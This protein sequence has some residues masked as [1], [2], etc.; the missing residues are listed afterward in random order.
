MTPPNA[1]L[2]FHLHSAIVVT[3]A[4]IPGK[5]APVLLTAAMVE[6]MGRGSVIVDLAAE[7]GGNCEL[8]RAGEDV[9]AH[10]VL[11]RGPVN[12][13]ATVPRHAS[14]M[15]SHNVTAFLLNMI[16]EGEMAVD[17]DDEIA[18]ES[19]LTHGGEIVHAGVLEKLR[20]D[21]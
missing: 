8:T 17:S 13:P 12:L 10:G 7:S 18:R 5:P 20:S 15:Y 2:I 4:A 19:R 14:R 11:I 21:P 3:T 1:L 6:G 9:E 16:E